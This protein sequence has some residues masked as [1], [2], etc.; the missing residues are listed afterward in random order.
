MNISPPGAETCSDQP[1][2]SQRGSGLDFWLVPG[3]KRL[4]RGY[5][6][7]DDLLWIPPIYGGFMGLMMVKL[8][9]KI[10]IKNDMGFSIDIELGCIYIY[11]LYH[12][13]IVGQYCEW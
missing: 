12:P 2:V 11:I 10:V 7:M 5:P 6:K 13:L 9:V 3:L 8:M 1:D 4:R